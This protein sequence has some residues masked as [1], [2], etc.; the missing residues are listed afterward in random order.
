MTTLTPPLLA[1]MEGR[2]PRARREVIPAP[3]ESKLHSDVANLLRDHCLP[4]WR[5]THINRKCKDAREGKIMKDMGV[6]PGWPDFLLISPFN[7]R[8]IHGLEL[9]RSAKDI[10]SKEQYDWQC[11]CL[12]HGGRYAV[13]WTIDQ[14]LTSL[15]SWGCLRIKYQ[16]W[17]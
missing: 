7:D 13:A 2:K 6:N 8:N 3:R 17:V 1:M 12:L 4:E 11:W 5:W 15:E 9:K 14:V 16:P 10:L